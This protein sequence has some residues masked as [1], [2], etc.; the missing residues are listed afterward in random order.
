[1]PKC[2]RLLA[3]LVAADAQA[4]DLEPKAVRIVASQ[5]LAPHLGDA[6]HAVRT[7]GRFRVAALA[8]KLIPAGRVVRA[9]EDEAPHPGPPRCFVGVVD[10][11]DVRLQ[12]R[13][14]LVRVVVRLGVHVHDRIL[15]GKCLGHGV[16][17]VEVQH[18]KPR[19][20]LRPDAT[21]R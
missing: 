20:V 4:N 21:S 6:V 7:R 15:P 10:A 17:V 8:G 9:G 2:R 3:V 18:P 14:Q 1:M 12:I 16:D 11:D 13:P 5:R 19:I